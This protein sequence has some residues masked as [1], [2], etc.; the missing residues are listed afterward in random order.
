M[1]RLK[2]VGRIWEL[3]FLRGIA[4]I[5]M[6]YFHI[7]FDLNEIFNYPISYSSG[8]NYYIGKVSV[9]LFIIISGISSSLS[10]NNIK[11]GLKV[12]AIAIIIT[13]VTHLFG[14]EIG[15]KFGILHLLG[16]CMILY[17]VF[18]KFSW[19]ILLIL[20]SVFIIIGDLFDRIY[21]DFNYLFV[22]GLRSTQFQSSDYYPF[23]PW[24]GLFLLGI[25]LSKL[26]YTKRSSLF[27]FDIKDNIISK[28]GRNTLLVYV[29]HQ[30]I[31]LTIIYLI[32]KLFNIINK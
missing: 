22:I 19:Y 28:L 13:V 23:F 3:D 2:T 30:P 17:P 18:A 9:I 24:S 15:I 6:I 20:G 31:I 32:Q 1:K 5:L 16:I 21:V 29:L 12:L 14:S 27:N 4:L 25:A 7:V 11:R 8:I 26:I 10:K